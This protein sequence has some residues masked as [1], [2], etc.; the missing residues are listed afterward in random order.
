MKIVGGQFGVSGSASLNE[1]DLTIKGAKRGVYTCDQVRAVNTEVVKEKKF[2]ITGFILGA[3]VLGVLFAALF[4]FLGAIIGIALSVVGSFYSKKHHF[5]DVQFAD[6]MSVRLQCS[7]Y[8]ANEL[9]M[10]GAKKEEEAH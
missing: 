1:K 6:G 5:A 4:G 8:S 10:F 7:G 2:G 3:I 9:V